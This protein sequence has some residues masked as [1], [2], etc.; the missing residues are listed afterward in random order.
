MSPET[1]VLKAAELL[2]KHHSLNRTLGDIIREQRAR[3]EAEAPPSLSHQW[4]IDRFFDL[5]LARFGV[6]YRVVGGRDGKAAK[7]L[8]AF[9]EATQEEITRRMQAALEDPW[10]QKAGSL[11]LFVS[12]WSNYGLQPAAPTIGQRLREC[13]GLDDNGRPVYA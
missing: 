1:R 6:P 3:V 4:A 7:V 10:F 11:S 13:V 2:A 5:W 8:V 12:R 9:P